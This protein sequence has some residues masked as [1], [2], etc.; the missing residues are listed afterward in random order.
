MKT[1]AN[2]GPHELKIRS[3]SAKVTVATPPTTR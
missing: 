2:E 1:F 3:S